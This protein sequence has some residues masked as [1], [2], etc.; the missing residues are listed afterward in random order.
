MADRELLVRI[1][2]DDRDLQRAFKNSE[3]GAGRFESRMSKLNQSL[4]GGLT[5]GFGGG[6]ALLF[7]S[8]AFIGT[9]ALTKAISESIQAASAL[10]EEISKSRQI[11]GDSSVAIE[12]WAQTTASAI[13]VAEVEAL[14]AT[15]TF[16]NLFATVGLGQQQAGEMSQE[17]VQLAADLASFNNADIS[18]VLTAIRSGLIGEAEPLR[19]YGVL[20]SE[21]RVQQQAMAASGKENVKELT[22]QEKALA[23]YQIIL[24]DTAVAQG[25]FA[26]TSGGLANQTRVLR[27]R[28]QDTQAELG[29]KLLPTMLR[30][31]EVA[32]DLID[33]IDQDPFR[34]LDTEKLKDID[35]KGFREMRDRL[36]EIKG[37]GAGVV[38]ILD[39]I[40]LRATQI[41]ELAPPGGPDSQGGPRGP[42]AVAASNLRVD[43]ENELDAA[44]RAKRELAK[45]RKEFGE[46]T[47]GLG[48]KLDKAGL[49]AGLDDDIAALRELERAILRQIQREGKT[50]VLVDQLTQVRLKIASTVEKQALDA[51]QA[52]QDAVD[53]MFDALDLNLERAQATSGLKDDQAALRDIEQA[54]LKR[55][56]IEGETTDLLRRLFQVR[57][58]Q[59]AVAQELREQA[60]KEFQGDIFERFGLTREGDERVPGGA[61]LRKRAR[62]LLD[63]IKGTALDTDKNRQILRGIINT[64]NK[65]FRQAGRAV[66]QAALDLLNDISSAF[67]QG[68]TKGP[69]TKTSGL[70]TKKI[71]EGLG[72]SPEEINELRGR[73]S[74]INTAG[75]QL[76]A[77][78][79]PT[80]MAGAASF[81]GAQG[82]I[83]V[84]SHTTINL[85]GQQVAKVVT[86]Q[87]QKTK[88]RN[89]A[90]KR[91]PNRNR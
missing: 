2:G 60:Q 4:R 40:I 7:G 12:S 26:R 57:Q 49:T 27:A 50:F 5:G 6:S 45:L 15:G 20:L 48:L 76:G 88:R 32:N 41:Q 59:A 18:D 51:A 43:A 36:A 85:D 70:N 78:A 83:V 44:K 25:D 68:G 8:G 11:F 28:L 22:N 52:A 66:R 75:R 69:L 34:N 64:T 74:S 54:I 87:Q 23:R 73:L 67:D 19:R 53:A 91:G 10:N 42:G 38:E 33:V 84:E 77:I 39:E 13:G 16:G 58:E 35:V 65:E 21:T 71:L 9:A 90:Q 46:L 47:K 3:R 56:E 82:A 1:I 30:L 55:I 81:G 63:M 80:A 14:R 37:E 61:A 24:S 89:P 17:L 72:L 31:T 62:N 29:T 79:S 86:K